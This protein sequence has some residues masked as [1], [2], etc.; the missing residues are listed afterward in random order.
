MKILA[1]WKLWGRKPTHIPTVITANSSP[2]LAGEMVPVWT[3]WW[4]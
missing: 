1:G 4:E 3:S 2:E